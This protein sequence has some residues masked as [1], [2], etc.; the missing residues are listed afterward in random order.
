M[1][2]PG[3]TEEYSVYIRRVSSARRTETSAGRTRTAKS[4]ATSHCRS[5]LAFSRWPNDTIRSQCQQAQK[6][7]EGARGLARE[8]TNVD[9]G[10]ECDRQART[11]NQ[12]NRR[13]S[14]EKARSSLDRH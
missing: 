9:Y 6:T 8:K 14:I 7:R 5:R 12:H 11:H 13:R 2:F 3:W 10:K 1:K 4:K